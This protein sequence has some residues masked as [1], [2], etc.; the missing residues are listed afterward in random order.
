MNNDGFRYGAI[1]LQKEIE[2]SL[3]ILGIL[4]RVFGRG[5]TY[6]SINAKLS[7]TEKY[8]IGGHLLQDAIGIRVVL[9][10]Q[11]DIDH[12]KTIL[13]SNYIFDS[14]SSTID[15]PSKNE[16]SVTRYNLI[17]KTPN[18]INTL[19]D[20]AIKD[21][22]IDSTF[23]VQ[24][25]TLLSEGWHEVEHDLRYKCPAHWNGHDDLSRALNGIMATL[26]TSDWG[27]RKIFDDLAYKHYKDRQWGAMLHTSLRMRLVPT[28]STEICTILNSD[29]LIAK[30][31]FRINKSQVIESLI[32]LERSIPL[33][34]DNIVYLW[35]FLSINSDLL[36]KITP[37]YIK[38]SFEKSLV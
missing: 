28:L 35:N 5:K 19:I 26:E 38:S 31:L 34:T 1:M 22:A 6:D 9:Y 33:N 11:E 16:F 4:C 7:K 3:N 36:D 24:I 17:F 12:V 20:N 15:L 32:K 2:E 23:E 27:M 25:R 21:K 30:S 18:H 13:C 8:S 37:L 29:S 14:K 10:F